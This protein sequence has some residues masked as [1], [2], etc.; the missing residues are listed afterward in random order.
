MRISVIG[1]GNVG[2]ALSRRL[3][4]AGHEV[5]V[6]VRDPLDPKHEALPVATAE[7][8]A[9][10]GDVVF[11]AVPWKSTEQICESLAEILQGKVMVDCT[12]PIAA[13]FSGLELGHRDSGGEQVGR[14][15]P[16]S[17]VVKAFNTIGFGIMEN[18]DF[19]GTPAMLTI[20]GDDAGAKSIVSQLATDIGFAPIDVGPLARS[21]QTEALAWLWISLS[22]RDG[23][24]FA[25]TRVQRP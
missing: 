1:S 19:H 22:I 21:V 3:I 8:A 18:P 13:D 17:K 16:G 2:G 6:G 25:F 15:L 9:R 14:W 4:D 5:I 23:R 20:A 11:L 24:N 7:D 12:N 10:F